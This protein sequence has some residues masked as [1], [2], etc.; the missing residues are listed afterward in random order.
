MTDRNLVGMG[1]A[2]MDSWKIANAAFGIARAT[3]ES[4]SKTVADTRLDSDANNELDLK[5]SIANSFNE[6]SHIR[7]TSIDS[8]L[9]YL[10][11]GGEVDGRLLN[12]TLKAHSF[13]THNPMFQE[14]LREVNE[15]WLFA[16]IVD[17]I[18]HF[19]RTYIGT[20]SQCTQCM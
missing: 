18:W 1:S 10:M 6:F 13:L 3:F 4:L 2:L 14:T 12:E 5:Q 17:I 15:R 20:S 16:G 9:R 8:N 19:E 11:G 7:T